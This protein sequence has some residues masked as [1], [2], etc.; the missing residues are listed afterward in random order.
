LEEEGMM[1]KGAHYSVFTENYGPDRYQEGDL[2]LPEAEAMGAI[3]LFHGGFWAMPY[4]R[5]QLGEVSKRLASHGYIVWNIEYRRV[6]YLGG[7]W[8]G[9]FEDSVLAVNRITE[10]V[11]HHARN[12]IQNLYFAGHSAGGQL[13]L[14][15]GREDNHVT[16]AAVNVKPRAVIGLA[17]V[18]DLRKCHEER[19]GDTE[20]SN[21]LGGSPEE[22]DER[23]RLAS[24]IEILPLSVP[25]LIIQGKEDEAL[26]I[27]WTRDYA[28]KVRKLGGYIDLVEMD[29][30]GHFDFIDANS[31]SIDCLLNWLDLDAAG[32]HPHS[33]Q[34]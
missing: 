13:A 9:T 24:P 20:V 14:W 5:S 8:T 7:G 2:Y 15:L 28:S 17:P 30:G 16:S 21:L 29:K 32:K 25:Q 23:Y 18:V 22:K 11:K 4:D 27:A 10:L 1:E 26:P 6:G 31:E 3:C 33:T 12:N 19:I 34:K